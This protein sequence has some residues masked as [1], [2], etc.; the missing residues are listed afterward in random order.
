MRHK[1]NFLSLITALLL[2]GGM[3]GVA[4]CA[5]AASPTVE[6]VGIAS[7]A[8]MWGNSHG[9]LARGPAGGPERFY[10]GYYSSTGSALVG[11]DPKT[12]E[13]TEVKFG[14]LGGYG[15]DVGP[16]QALYVGGVAPGDLYR[17]DLVTGQMRSLGGHQFDC[18]YIFGCAA[19]PENKRIY[20]ATYPKAKLL[21]YNP[22]TSELRDL[23]RMSPAETYCYA[24]CVDAFGKVW[25]G[26]GTHADLVVYDP[27]TGKHQSVL[28]ADFKQNSLVVALASSGDYVFCMLL[29]DGKLLVFDA[30]TRQL[31]RVLNRPEGS[32]NYRPTMGA[33]PG[34]MYF[35]SEPDGS[36]YH[37]SVAKN[38]FRKLAERLGQCELV[39]DGRIVYGM[40]DQDFFAFD[41]KKNRTL[42]RIRLA[43]SPD[44]MNLMTLCTGKDGFV[45]GSTFINQHIFR[46]APKT[47]AITDLGKAIRWAGQVD[48]MC[49]GRDANIYMG[50]YIEAVTSVYDPAKRW[51]PGTKP[52]SNPREIGPLGKGQYRTAA[53][54]QGPDGMLYI[55]SVP[56]Y[57]SG[58]K[59]AFSRVNPAN[60]EITVWQD[61][62][63]E[64]SVSAVVADDR[65]V[66]GAGGGKLF[67]FDPQQGKSIWMTN[68]AVSAMVLASTGD[69]MGT[70]NGRLFIFSPKEKKVILEKPIPR[71]NFSF[72]CT[73]PDGSSY[74]INAS[75]I[76]RIAPG[77]W[78]VT[79]LLAEGGRFLTADAESNLYFARG[80]Q[81]FRL[82]Q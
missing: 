34:E 75:H 26:M 58:P 19:S 27:V 78:E 29:F 81:V 54:A 74:G 42:R 43:E 12:G 1:T 56:S 63:P 59:G 70:G 52:D 35:Y 24:V 67:V 46:I 80:A 14:S 15:L 77:T 64:G 44:G 16:D 79:E 11:V 37:Y 4:L 49:A 13:R 82:R 50:S 72:M 45:Y 23:G 30:R 2:S 28:P 60:N 69:L 41:L 3:F 9:R 66:F 31:I 51:L 25:A 8:V 32:A 39:K 55:G 22:E 73:A 48:S 6:P 18:C 36:L 5:V 33:P 53:C 65:Y 76:A 47:S 38:R 40:D 62:V 71:G 7:R 57:N 20:A 21:E 68:L 17:Y 10:I 61:L